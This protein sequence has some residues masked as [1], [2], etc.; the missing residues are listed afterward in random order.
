MRSNR[1]PVIL[2]TVG[3][4]I[5]MLV[6]GVALGS[7]AFPMIKT[8]TTLQLSTVTFT[9]SSTQTTTTTATTGVTST[10]VSLSN[11]TYPVLA[12]VERPV[13][14]VIYEPTCVTI[15]GHKTTTYTS[16]P[17]MQST[18]ETYIF[19]S[20]PPSSPTF[21]VTIT[22]NNTATVSDETISQSISC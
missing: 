1:R 11:Q 12:I 7:A 3:V 14:V 5:V 10:M 22:T 16:G 6:I 4:A 20:I 2:R 18:T 17:G 9:T 19:P 15:S 13:L 21:L 8:E